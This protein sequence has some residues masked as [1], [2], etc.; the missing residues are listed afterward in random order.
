[1]NLAF[2]HHHNPVI[3]ARIIIDL[4]LS[5]ATSRI[6]AAAK[7]Q[8]N[9]SEHVRGNYACACVVLSDLGTDAKRCANLTQILD[10]N[11]IMPEECARVFYVCVIFFHARLF[12]RSLACGVF[13]AVN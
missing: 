1:M 7:R 4:K 9:G 2:V 13:C 11:T 5:K 12:A 8:R 6:F 3:N 10:S